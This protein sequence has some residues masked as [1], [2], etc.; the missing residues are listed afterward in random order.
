METFQRTVTVKK[1]ERTTVLFNG[2][3]EPKDDNDDDIRTI[4]GPFD[5]LRVK[6]PA[7]V[8]EVKVNL[9][10]FESEQQARR[11]N[12]DRWKEEAFNLEE[13]DGVQIVRLP[14][15]RSRVLT[16]TPQDNAILPG[17]IAGWSKVEIELVGTGDGDVDIELSVAPDNVGAI[18]MGRLQMSIDTQ[19][20]TRLRIE[21]VC[22]ALERLQATLLARRPVKDSGV[23]IASVE[24]SKEPV[25]I[26]RWSIEPI[27]SA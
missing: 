23:I 24:G 9:T 3:R 1:G 11:S 21:D 17:W 8:V 13:A 6:G 5:S 2:F 7:A 25:E 19:A 10:Y 26:G 20:H 16:R 22:F 12:P 4:L 18:P 14:I 27:A 15:E